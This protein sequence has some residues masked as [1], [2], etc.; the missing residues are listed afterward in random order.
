[1]QTSSH[2]EATVNF[3]SLLDRLHLA[4]PGTWV[5]V[6]EDEAFVR[7]VTVEIL[8]AAGYH[9]LKARHAVE[10]T[11]VFRQCEE[12]VDLLVTDVVL[13]GRNGRDLARELTRLRPDLKTIFISGYPNNVVRNAALDDRWLYLSKPFSVESLMRKVHEALA[14]G[15]ERTNS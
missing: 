3:D 9:V 10:A 7:E 1:M 12:K 2:S 5:L 8:Q 11:A 15:R 4:Q 13:P 6:V 14:G